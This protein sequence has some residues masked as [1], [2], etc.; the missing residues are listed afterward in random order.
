MN[1]ARR[2][3]LISTGATHL[4]PDIIRLFVVFNTYPASKAEAWALFL[5]RK[6]IVKNFVHL[7]F[8]AVNTNFLV[9]VSHH[10][11]MQ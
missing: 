2:N 5:L 8:I 9:P 7:I 6:V 4:Y 1:I 11:Y 3:T 10:S